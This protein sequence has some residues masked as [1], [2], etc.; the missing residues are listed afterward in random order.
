VVRCLSVTPTVNVHTLWSVHDMVCE[1]KIRY[2]V[3]G[4][5]GCLVRLEEE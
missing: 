4:G 3:D 5:E 2:E 1:S